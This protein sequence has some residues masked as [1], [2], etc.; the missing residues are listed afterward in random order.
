[1]QTATDPTNEATHSS[2][3]ARTKAEYIARGLPSGAT[4]YLR[5]AAID[6][7]SESGYG[8]WSAWI[9]GTAR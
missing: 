3:M 6:P 1:V 2:L 4:I 9:L 8:A 7:T 5:V